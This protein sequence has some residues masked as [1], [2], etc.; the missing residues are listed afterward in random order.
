M[1]EQGETAN[2]PD[3]QQAAQRRRSVSGKVRQVR[4]RLTSHTGTNPAFDRDLT[5]AYAR[6]QTGIALVVPLLAIIIAGM[7]T[8]WVPWSES[9]VWLAGVLIS[10]GILTYLCRRF[11]L[12]RTHKLSADLWERRFFAAEFLNGVMWSTMAFLSVPTHETEPI[13]FMFAVLIVVLAMRTLTASNLPMASLAGTLPITAAIV[14]RFS[15]LGEPLYYAMAGLAAGA[16]VFFMIIAR[17][18]QSTVLAMFGLRKEK[19]AL[20]GELEQATALSE[21]ARRRAEEA[22]LAKSRFLATMSHELRTPLNA[23]LGF[24]EVLKDEILGK[25]SVPAYKEYSGDIHRSGQH[26]LELINEIL[27]LSRIEAGRY[28]LQEEAVSLPGTVQDCH[29]LTKLRADQR[30][31]TIEEVFEVDLPK[32]W[33][34]ERA[35]RQIVLNLLTNAVKFSPN[36]SKVTLTVGWTSGGGQYLSVKDSGPGIHEDEIPTVLQTFGRGSVAM[37]NADEGT[38]LG[39][40]IVMKLIE[41]HGG[42]FDFRSKLREGTEAIVIFPRERVMKALPPLED[43]KPALRLRRRSAA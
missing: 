38:G 15:M 18:F 32:I 23:I 40:P 24:S 14:L 35:V 34:D 13:I 4:E 39:L 5:L 12:G 8:V 2:L 21:E 25:H 6:N 42:R 37:K 26:L 10:N 20:I 29:H 22:N 9:S 16:Q 27:D 7:M 17:Q 11:E 36:G 28:A 1:T 3:Q 41:L 30:G 19:D 31:I 33:V 43:E